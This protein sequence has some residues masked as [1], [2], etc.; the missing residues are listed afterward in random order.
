LN[1][2]YYR[3]QIEAK[4]KQRLD[5]ER[6]AADE[7]KREAEKRKAASRARTDA[8]RSTSSSSVSG[9][10]R[11]AERLE[12]EANSAAR[13][14]ARWQAKA[15][16]LSKQE[17]DLLS[18]LTKAELEESKT[19]ERERKRESQRAA[20]QAET[21]TRAI[22]RAIDDTTTLVEGTVRDLRQPKPERLRVLHLGASSDGGLRVGREQSRIRAAVESALHRDLVEFDFRPAATTRDL[23][24]GITRFRPHIIHFSGHGDI[25][26]LEF[27][28]EL[29]E[30]HV[31]IEVKANA[32]ASAISATDDPPILVVLNSCH[33][34]EQLAILV[35]RVV[36]FAIG[37]ADSISDGDAI[38]Y[39]SQFYAA[40]ANGQSIQSAHRSGKASLELLGLTG[41]DLPVLE[42]ALDVDPSKAL[43]VKPPRN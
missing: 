1:P 29:D 12:A 17:A 40:V 7:R 31:G 41:A 16:D 35:E 8:S 27:E 28:D 32:F 33:S 19:L 30:P 2:S 37:M 20:R 43:L 24:D 39:S 34:S 23:L 25:E 22:W 26:L 15:A 6:K 42:H 36:P 18:K 11:T 13:D 21:Q 4:R 38:A 3:S 10:L 5:A 14:A 9:K